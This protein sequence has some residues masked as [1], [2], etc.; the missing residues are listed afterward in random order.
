MYQAMAMLVQVFVIF[1]LF[2]GDTVA[3]RV[4]VLEDVTCWPHLLQEHL[5]NRFVLGT[6][7][8]HKAG[9]TNVQLQAVAPSLLC[10]KLTPGPR[11]TYSPCHFWQHHC[12]VIKSARED[13]VDIF[14]AL[15]ATC[16]CRTNCQRAV[17]CAAILSQCSWGSTPALA[18]DS[19]IFSPCS[20]V[21]VIK[22]TVLPCIRWNLATTSA[23]IVE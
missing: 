4:R 7:R 3:A 2:A 23:A 1:V 11:R 16:W 12:N 8:A 19:A 9:V 20:S 14:N 22:L 6:C 21:P 17:Y 18:A 13:A 15:S 10:A 5:H